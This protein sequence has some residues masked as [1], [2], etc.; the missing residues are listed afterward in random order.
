M[1]RENISESEYITTGSETVQ[2]QLLSPKIV[3]LLQPFLENK[4]E[5]VQTESMTVEGTKYT[6]NGCVITSIANDYNNFGKIC[7]IYVTGGIGYIVCQYLVVVQSCRH[8][9]AYH[10]E[11]LDSYSLFKPHEL[12]DYH[13]LGIF[14]KEGKHCYIKVA[15]EIQLS[16]QSYVCLRLC[17]IFNTIYNNI[18]CMLFL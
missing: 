1:Q 10:V 17:Y 16:C 5:V 3:N 14:P 7:N 6:A 15:C 11:F 8:Y 2:L 18:I 12:L 4:L 9:H 13:S